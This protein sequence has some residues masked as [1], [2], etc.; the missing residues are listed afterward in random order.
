MRQDFVGRQQLSLLP[1]R[2][3]MAQRADATEEAYRVLGD[4]LVAKGFAEMRIMVVGA[5]GSYPAAVA[6]SHLLRHGLS[7]PPRTEAATP[8][9]A[10]QILSQDDEVAGCGC[11]PQYDIVIGVSY[12]GRT[13]DIKAVYEGCRRRGIPFMLVTGADREA[14]REEYP[15]G[16][17][18]AIVSYH[19]AEDETG[20]ER[21]MISMFSTL[22]PAIVFD[23]NI[24]S[25]WQWRFD[26]YG[27][28]QEEGER[29]VSGLDVPGIAKAIARCPVVHV[30]YEWRT[31][32]VAADIASKLMESGIAN[33]IL[34]EKKNFSHG[35]YT[36]LY[37]QDF[38]MVI[39]VSRLVIAEHTPSWDEVRFAHGNDYDGELDRFLRDLCKEKSAVYIE[40]GNGLVRTGRLLLAEMFKLPYMVVAIGEELGVDISKPFAP[41]PFPEAPKGLYGFVG[42]F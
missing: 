27:K 10:L 1:E 14:L 18:L 23:D 11:G 22:M 16:D 35:L 29:F 42:G 39:N 30:I 32:G 41:D 17:S 34:H 7:V 33:V 36:L 40:M 20:R 6:V 15:D 3:R 26:T 38:A 24:H 5:G 25:N 12:S 4:L 13:P 2:I 37:R 9:T 28:L 19:N 21:G 8:Q 31:Y